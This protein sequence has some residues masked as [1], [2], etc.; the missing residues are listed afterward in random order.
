MKHKV[1][2]IDGHREPKLPPKP[3]YPDGIDLDVSAGAKLNCTVALSY[4]AKRCGFYL[5]ICSGCDQRTLVT[6]AGR[7]DDP[8]SIKIACNRNGDS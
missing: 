7:R 5:I 1:T 8:R 6:T 3:D 4:P 2:W